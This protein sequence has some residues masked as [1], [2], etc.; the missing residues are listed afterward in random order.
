MSLAQQLKYQT[1]G[2]AFKSH[3][4]GVRRKLDDATRVQ[5]AAPF[6][7]EPA[8][9]V[10]SKCLLDT[11]SEPYRA[12]VDVI[13]RARRYWK[14]MTVFFPVK[15]VRLIRRDLVDAFDA[16]MKRFADE[17][18][19]ATDVLRDEYKTLKQ[20]ARK[21]LGQLY[22][23]SDYP[24]P[25]TL[26]EEFAIE[27]SFPSVDPPNFLKQLNPKLYEQEQARVA[28]RFQEAMAAAEQALAAEMQQLVSHLV[29]RL[30]RNESGTPKKLNEKAMNG[31][32]EFVERINSFSV[33]T[34]P[35]LD[36]LVKQIE[37]ISKGVDVQQINANGAA[38]QHLFNTMTTL[39]EQ[40]DSML[41]DQPDRRIELED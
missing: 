2:V 40:L 1:A 33:H 23:P 21:D 13:T 28:A 35:E 10:A 32:A 39:K 14:A 12:V 25:E 24:D 7:A 17:L 9:L 3:K 8:C 26:L 19:S 6:G 37:Q 34:S 31:L 11:Q 27:W 18:K 41:V 30:G 5:A 38:Q 36:A 15:G 4:F 16:E 22:N 29:D 20:Q